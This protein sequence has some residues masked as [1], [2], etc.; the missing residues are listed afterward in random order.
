MCHLTPT[1]ATL[2]ESLR[3]FPKS[4]RGAGKRAIKD[5]IKWNY[6]ITKKTGCG[7]HVSLNPGLLNDI[8]N[9]LDH[10]VDSGD[11]PPRARPISDLKTQP[12]TVTRGEKI[13]KGAAAEYRYH[14]SA[15]EPGLYA[16]LVSVRNQQHKIVLGSFSDPDSLLARAVRGLDSIK[17]TFTKADLNSLGP[18]IVGNKQPV[19]AIVDMLCKF[20]YMRSAGGKKYAR[21][22]KQLPRPP[23]DRF[24]Q[25]D[26]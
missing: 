19:H 17:P 13:V 16:C 18:Q 15:A 11:F 23:M 20:G 10:N 12:I 8:R 14:E 22:S 7:D 21:T 6:I 24:L 26:Q 25:T 9:H 4:E 3:M 2:P 1:H 5:L